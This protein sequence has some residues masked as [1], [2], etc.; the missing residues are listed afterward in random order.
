[1]KISF[2]LLDTISKISM[3]FVK[4]SYYL[5]YCLLHFVI[6]KS[7]IHARNTHTRK[8]E[9]RNTSYTRRSRRSQTSYRVVTRKTTNRTDFYERLVVCPRNYRANIVHLWSFIL[10]SRLFLF[11]QLFLYTLVF[12]SRLIQLLDRAFI[13]KRELVECHLN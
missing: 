5:S 2:F 6:L 4:N 9:L 13:E 1:M 12:L 11:S 10:Y 3:S 8:K 7:M